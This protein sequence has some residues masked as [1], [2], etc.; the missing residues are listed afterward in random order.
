MDAVGVI[1]GCTFSRCSLHSVRSAPPFC[2]GLVA[3]LQLDWRRFSR[4]EQRCLSSTAFC[5][6]HNPFVSGWA[7]ICRQG[8]S[9][10]TDQGT[11]GLLV[12]VCLSLRCLQAALC[13][14]TLAPVQLQAEKR[15]GFAFHRSHRRR[16]AGVARAILNPEEDPILKEAIKVTSPFHEC[17]ML[18]KSPH[19]FA[20]L[21]ERVEV[22]CAVERF[23]DSSLL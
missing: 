8:W 7:V 5:L 2:H 10:I 22:Q 15:R 6:F 11:I 17:V 23:H 9:Q 4:I 18:D 13:S 21:P 12:P 3:S 14:T 1:R 16:E 19:E 20:I